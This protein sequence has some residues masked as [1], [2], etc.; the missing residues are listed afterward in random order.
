M[1]RDDVSAT[2]DLLLSSVVL[3]LIDRLSSESA[4]FSI[5]QPDSTVPALLEFPTNSSTT[6]QK[7]TD[8][9]S[10]SRFIVGAD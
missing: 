9:S 4:V 6:T 1:M 7:I 3:F 8:S 10:N 5:T 2:R